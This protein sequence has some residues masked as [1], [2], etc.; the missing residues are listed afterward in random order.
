[1]ASDQSARTG[2]ETVIAQLATHCA[3]A[4]N[5]R[6]AARILFGKSSPNSTHTTGPHDM[7]NA[8]T[9]KLAAINAIGPEAPV[10]TGL[11]S[12]SVP[13]VPKITAMVARVIVMP[14][15]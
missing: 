3:A 6:A 4:A 1:M 11:P 8:T 14:A 12:A 5:D 7:P 10:S 13:A 9:N 2:N 15:E